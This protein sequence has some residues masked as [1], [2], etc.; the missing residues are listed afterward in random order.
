MKKELAPYTHFVIKKQNISEYLKNKNIKHLAYILKT[1]YIDKETKEIVSIYTNKYPVIAK[2]K[3]DFGYVEIKETNN[4]VFQEEKREFTHQ[5]FKEKT[6]SEYLLDRTPKEGYKQI[7]R[8]INLDT[9][10]ILLLYQNNVPV[11]VEKGKENDYG[12]QKKDE[13][14]IIYDTRKE[15]FTHIIKRKINNIQILKELKKIDGYKISKITYENGLN[16]Y[17]QNIVPVYIMK[18][19]ENQFGI[20]EERQLSGFYYGKTNATTIESCQT[21]LEEIYG[22][23][24]EKAKSEE[25]K[26]KAKE[27]YKKNLKELKDSYQKDIPDWA[28]VTAV[29]RLSPYYCQVFF[30]SKT[31]VDVTETYN[32]YLGRYELK[33]V[34]KEN[35]YEHPKYQIKN[36]YCHNIKKEYKISEYMQKEK[37]LLGYCLLKTTIDLKRKKIIC[38]YSNEEPV[39][40]KENSE[41]GYPVTRIRFTDSLINEKIVSPKK[42][43]E[44][45]IP[46]WAEIIS[47]DQIN[48]YNVVL[49]YKN[50]E[51]TRLLLKEKFNPEKGDY[52]IIDTLIE[53]KNVLKRTK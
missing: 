51:D 21:E 31:Q 38:Y 15:A 5:V 33:Q 8:A 35:S 17:F 47:Y 37:E 23:M 29:K 30:Q 10:K 41:F 53:E 12:T 24:L 4:I 18:T 19:E 34:E 48:E 11:L 43:Y 9:K 45:D 2:E 1:V 50:K 52:E 40:V 6:I 20:K 32:S 46:N 16:V 14:K 22:R 49:Y 26:E 7:G 36:Q 25:E 39:Y 28:M 44:N 3:E 13:N 42:S 27:Y